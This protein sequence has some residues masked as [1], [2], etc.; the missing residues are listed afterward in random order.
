MRQKRYERPLTTHEAPV[1]TTDTAELTRSE[2]A[3]IN[4]AIPASV[5][6]PLITCI[7]DDGDFRLL[8]RFTLLLRQ[9][10]ARTFQRWKS[11]LLPEAALS[12]AQGPE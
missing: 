9:F 2:C 10:L 1:F 4:L 3:E 7:A 6:R 12:I 11:G 8:H 5:V